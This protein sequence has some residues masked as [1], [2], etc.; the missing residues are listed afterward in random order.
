M[1][2]N[3]FVWVLVLLLA[4]VVVSATDDLRVGRLDARVSSDLIIVDGVIYGSDNVNASDGFMDV[5]CRH[6]NGSMN[7][8]V[9]LAGNVPYSW[10]Y[11]S[12]GL[13][14]SFFIY[15]NNSDLVCKKGDFAWVQLYDGNEYVSREVVITRHHHHH[16]VDSGDDN[17]EIPEFGVIAGAVALLGCVGIY[18]FRR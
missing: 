9:L 3:I 5:F 17:N 8:T 14:S 16:S 1:N 15:G 18:L 4:V 6:D 11:S 7:I 13:Q 12:N 10:S 2:K